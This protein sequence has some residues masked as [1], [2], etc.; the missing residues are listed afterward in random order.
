MFQISLTV[1]LR[2]STPP[3]SKNLSPL[4]FSPNAVNGHTHN[5][6][7]NL[8]ATTGYSPLSFF[9]LRL[10]LPWT[11]TQTAKRTTVLSNEPNHHADECKTEP[12]PN[13]ISHTRNH[14]NL[15]QLHKSPPST[16]SLPLFPVLF[17]PSQL[18]LSKSPSMLFTLHFKRLL[19]L[20]LS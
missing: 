13:T 19:P 4:W 10:I 11:T 18:T 9:N 2:G 3:P 8:H 7:H 15:H 17:P 20:D 14:T 12:H 5:N 6:S 16:F 1:Y